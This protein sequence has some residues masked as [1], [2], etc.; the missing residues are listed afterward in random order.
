MAGYLDR[1]GAGKILVDSEPLSFDWLPNEL[2]GRDEALGE[3]A[4]MFMG[5]E[6]PNFSGRSIVI[7]P[8]GSGKTAIVRRFSEDLT[9]HLADTRRILPVHINCR[10]H[11]T[12]S[13]V[14]QRIAHYLDHRHPERGFSPGEIIQSIRRNLQNSGRHMLLV[15]DEVSVL[16]LREGDDLLYQLLRIDEGR[17]DAGTL[18]L[19]LVSQEPMVHLFE[20]AVK[21]RFGQSN[22]INLKPYE[23]KGLR[24]IVEQRSLAACRPGSIQDEAKSRIAGYAAETGDARLAIELLE[25]S[26]RRAEKKGDSEVTPEHV[27]PSSSHSSVIEPDQVD[28]LSDHQKMALLGLCRRLRRE[29]SVTSGDAERLYHVVCEEFEQDTRGHTSFWGY[30]KRLE[31]MGFIHAETRNTPKGRGRTTLIRAANILPATIEKRLEKDL[32]RV[33]NG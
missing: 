12:T 32:N 24:A 14:L 16:L 19:I 20:A 1:I 6:S 17:D 29:E 15:L 22:R 10:N 7:G 23:E 3:I 26:I 21:S 33:S 25:S 13:Q 9:K 4:S 8:V 27:E 18:S 5:I 31:E 2:V 11:P 28:S 30:I